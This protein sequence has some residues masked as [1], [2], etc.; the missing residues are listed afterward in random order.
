MGEIGKAIAAL[1]TAIIG[2]SV[3]AVIVSKKSATAD[4]LNAGGRA[5]AGILSVAVSPVAGQYAAQSSAGGGAS[6]LPPN[7]LGR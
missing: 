7:P 5:F 3:V 2:V 4:V 6:V 1:F